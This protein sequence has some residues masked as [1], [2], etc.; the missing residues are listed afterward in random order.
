VFSIWLFYWSIRKTPVLKWVFCLIAATPINMSLAASC[1]QDAIISG[2]AFLFTASVL[3]LALSPERE[4]TARSVL[5]PAIVGAL[6]AP[7]KAGAYA[8]M[9]AFF[10]FVP[11]R[12]AG[13]LSKYLGLVI[14]GVMPALF[15]FA[16][17]TLVSQHQVLSMVDQVPGLTGRSQLWGILEAPQQFLWLLAKTT[18]G[19][20][21]GYVAQFVGVLGWVDTILPRWVIIT[22]LVLFF[23]GAVLDDSAEARVSIQSK[24]VAGLVITFVYVGFQTIHYTFTPQ[25]S[26]VIVGFLG[27]YLIPLGPAFFLLFHNRHQIFGARFIS[28]FPIFIATFMLVV[29]P[30][31]LLTVV[32]RYFGEEQAT[33]KMWPDRRAA[34]DSRFHVALT[35]SN[36]FCQTFECPFD[37]LTGVSVAI[38][39]SGLPSDKMMTHYTFTLKD[40]VSGELVR[41]VS[42][43]SFALDKRFLL[44]I[45]FDPI[46]DSK[47]KNYKF[48]IFPTDTVVEAPISIRLSEPSFHTE[49]ETVVYG[50]KTERSVVFEL[51]FT[52]SGHG[53]KPQVCP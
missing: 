7:A 42:I 32:N 52:T 39:N 27:R 51:I 3:N 49:D 24:V 33:W 53:Q 1:S 20:Y 14:L 47:N 13:C 30:A 25:D 36:D 17:W 4:F 8:P 45:L 9:L 12:K 29:I 50:R 28:L 18:T 5:F 19:M 2:L 41:E 38:V 43:Q 10:L 48:T 15:T 35:S 44:D 21:R 46:L 6:L 26:T 37:G 22:Y 40:A 16:A 11:V 31:T 34:L 23:T